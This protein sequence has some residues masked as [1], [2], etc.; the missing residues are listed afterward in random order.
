MSPYETIDPTISSWAVENSIQWLTEYQGT[1]VRTFFLQL[2]GKE[3][4]QIWIDPPSGTNLIIHAV[5][6]RH[7]GKKRNS[8]D[9]PCTASTLFKSLDK[10]LD[11]ALK[12]LL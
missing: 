11:T 3:K 6:Y 4:V 9:F 8:K 12:W 2:E 10:A 7:G 1:E 5:Q